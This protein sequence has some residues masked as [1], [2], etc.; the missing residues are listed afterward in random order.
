MGAHGDAAEI[1]AHPWFAD[2]DLV[3]L[4]ALQ[5][6]PPLK[7]LQPGARR[8]TVDL[9]SNFHVRTGVSDMEMS[10]VPAKNL[11]KIAATDFS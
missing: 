6:E 8:D 9:A 3:K 4:E 11:A 2:L 5:L 7:A 10:M 1:L